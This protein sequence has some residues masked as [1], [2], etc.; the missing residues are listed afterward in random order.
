MWQGLNLCKN[1][2]CGKKQV[3]KVRSSINFPLIE[4]LK[5]FYASAKSFNKIN[6]AE[7]WSPDESFSDE[8][9]Q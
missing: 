4:T 2:T 8:D 5:Q 3:Q 6:E 9:F 7:K 1:T